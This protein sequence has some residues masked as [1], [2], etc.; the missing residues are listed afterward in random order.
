MLLDFTS[1]EWGKLKRWI[2]QELIEQ[3]PEIASQ[4]VDFVLEVL[5]SEP[6]TGN[7]ID[8]A[9]GRN[10]WVLSQLSGILNSPTLFVEQ[11]PSKVRDIKA[12]RDAGQSS[13][14]TSSVIVEHVPIRS[15]NEKEIRSSF[16]PYGALHSCKANMQNRQVVIDFQN[17]SCAIRST[18]A[19]TVF[20]NNR[21]VTVQ[22][23]RGKADAFEGLQLI[24]PLTSNLSQ[25]AKNSSSSAS[26]STSPPEIEVNR[27][28]QEA[29]TVQQATFEQNQ[30]TR[31]N[32]KNNLNERFDSKE[33]LL[34]SQQ[35]MLQELRRKVAELPEDDND[36]YLE[37]LSSEF[38]ELRNSMQKMGIA[39]DIML[40]IK[41]QKLNMDHPSELV[42][43]DA[44]ATALKKKRAKKSALLKKKVKRKR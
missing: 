9:H 29:Q 15:L 11:L 25:A 6:D 30:R 18:K 17:A 43:E 44:R 22:L 33:T 20:F 35:S 23:Y 41:V 40:E 21:F 10:H 1:E 7:G 4:L 5:K 26:L 36:G 2:T 12:A 8:T 42:I 24:A 28:I 3:E 39:P 27:H 14:P 31:E 37:Q 19:A 32:F 13:A 38:R 34:R 16:E